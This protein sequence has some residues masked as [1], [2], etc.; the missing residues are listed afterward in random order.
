MF[1]KAVRMPP[2]KL[3]LQRPLLLLCETWVDIFYPVNGAFLFTF[4]L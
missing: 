2:D 4:F 3:A 1:L